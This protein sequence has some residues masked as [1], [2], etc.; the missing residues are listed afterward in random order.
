MQRAIEVLGVGGQVEAILGEGGMLL[1]L[2]RCVDTL[3]GSKAR[4][5]W[6]W[7]L[8]DK[9]KEV[10]LI[11][12]SSLFDLSVLFS[13]SGKLDKGSRGVIPAVC[14]RIHF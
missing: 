6:G 1:H 7:R 2:W 12:L 9:A 13:E 4:L 11:V 3:P 8:V 14:K 10:L 5:K